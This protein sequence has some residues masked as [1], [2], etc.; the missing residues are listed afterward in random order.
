MPVQPRHHDN[1]SAH[2]RFLD[3]LPA[4]VHAVLH[5]V[6]GEVHVAVSV[7]ADPAAELQVAH[8]RFRYFH[9]DEIEVLA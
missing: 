4:T 3:G 5:E 6:D 1:T 2:L 9:P 7:D 8:G